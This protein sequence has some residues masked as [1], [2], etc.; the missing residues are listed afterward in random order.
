MFSK[1]FQ[2]ITFHIWYGML[3]A[4]ILFHLFMKTE[5]IKSFFLVFITLDL[6]FQIKYSHVYFF[7]INK[8]KKKRSVDIII[9]EGNLVDI[10]CST[11]VSSSGGNIE[12]IT[13]KLLRGSGGSFSQS[14]RAKRGGIKWASRLQRAEGSVCW[15]HNLPV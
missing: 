12:L 14:E 3:F 5:N 13:R 15:K 2:K 1:K 6:V 9:L 7:F 10:I 11:S 4:S 8:K